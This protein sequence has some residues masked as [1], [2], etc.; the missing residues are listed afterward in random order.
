MAEQMMW[1]SP[2]VS[3]RAKRWP[4]GRGIR[5]SASRG[6]CQFSG[7]RESSSP[8]PAP[9]GSMPFTGV[10]MSPVPKASSILPGP[11]EEPPRRPFRNFHSLPEASLIDMGDFAGGMLKYLRRHPVPRVSACRG[12]RQDDEAGTGSPRPSFSEEPGG[13]WPA[14]RHGRGRPAPMPAWRGAWPNR[15]APER[16]LAWHARP[17][18]PW[19]V[20]WPSAPG[21]RHWPLCWRRWRCDVIVID[22]SGTIV[23]QAAP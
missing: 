10:S 15:Q 16:P 1:F 6:D 4:S 14:C 22:R 17:G 11:R 3:S 8:I 20:K 12:V 23:G 7:P 13:F 2:S 18:C 5:Y 19:L 21:K 9:P